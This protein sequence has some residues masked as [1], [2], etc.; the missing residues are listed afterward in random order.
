MGDSRIAG[1]FILIGLIAIGLNIYS[2]YIINSAEVKEKS[3]TDFVV[4]MLCLDYN[5]TYVLAAPTSDEFCNKLSDYDLNTN[6]LISDCNSFYKDTGELGACLEIASIYG[7]RTDDCDNYAIEGEAR[8]SSGVESIKAHCEVLIS[9][10]PEDSPTGLLIREIFQ[11]TI[12]RRIREQMIA[13]IEAVPSL[14]S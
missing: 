8:T 2:V 5:G 13:A 3:F 1:I 9:A 10:A 7:L 11:D 12:T 14:S 6:D 4:P